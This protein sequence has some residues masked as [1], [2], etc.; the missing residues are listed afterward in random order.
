MF[1]AY[2]ELLFSILMP[3]FCFLLLAHRPLQPFNRLERKPDIEDCRLRREGE[4]SYKG[5]E[6]EEASM[7]RLSAA[8]SRRLSSS[9]GRSSPNPSTLV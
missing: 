6:F 3:A 5:E 2:L 9:S 1:A 7:P 4:T 8:S